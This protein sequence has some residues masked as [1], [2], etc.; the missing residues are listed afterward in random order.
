GFRQARVPVAD[1]LEGAGVGG[2]VRAR[3][4]PD[5]RLV[6]VDD[7]V[8][9]LQALDPVVRGGRVRGVVQ[10]ARRGLVE[11]LDGEGGL[12]AAGDAGDAGEGPGRDL[13]GDGLQVVAGGADHAQHLGLADW[14]ALV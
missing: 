11:G 6:D 4:A 12:A 3:R 1:R 7:L 14:P 13:G 9:E 2:R 5:R 10:P 8:E